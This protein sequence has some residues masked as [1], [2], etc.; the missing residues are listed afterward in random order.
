MQRRVRARKPLHKD[1]AR[2]CLGALLRVMGLMIQA[3]H[4]QNVMDAF[5]LTI[6]GLKMP[7]GLL[8]TSLLAGIP[9]W[10]RYMHAETL[11]QH[12]IIEER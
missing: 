6:V 7:E 4:L 11:V 1:V 2:R 5:R 3:P 10:V 9:K 8:S 12:R